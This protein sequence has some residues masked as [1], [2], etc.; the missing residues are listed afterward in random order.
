MPGCNAHCTVS[1]SAS[2]RAEDA[3]EGEVRA[4]YSKDELKLSYIQYVFYGYHS[5]NVIEYDD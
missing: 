4:A 5:T 2:L 3:A 1:K